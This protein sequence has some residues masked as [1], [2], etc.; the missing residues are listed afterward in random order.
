MITFLLVVSLFGSFNLKWYLPKGVSWVNTRVLVVDTDHDGYWELMFTTYG[1]IPRF[2]YVYE[3][4]PPSVWAVDS[5][6]QPGANVLWDGG[7]FDID[8]LADLAL[9][10]HSENPLADGIMI[11]ESPDSFSYPTQEMWRDTVGFA[12]VMPICSHDVDQDGLPEIFKV[13][14]Y[15]TDLEIY[16]CVGN[17]TYEHISTVVTSAPASSSSPIAFGDF[18]LDNQNDFTWGYLNGQYSVWECVGGNSYQEIVLQQLPT[19]NV[20]DCPTIP[21]ADGDGRPEFLIKGYNP[22]TARIEAFILEATGDNTYAVIESFDLAGGSVYYWGGLSDAGDVDGDSIPEILIEGCQTVYIAKA[23]GNDSF[24]IWETLP[25]WIDGS[26][27]RVFDLDGNGLSEVIISG[28]N[29]TRIYEYE[30]GG[31]NEVGSEDIERIS[32]EVFPNPFRDNT[33][34]TYELLKTPPEQI[35][36]LTIFNVCGRLVRRFEGLR[37]SIRGQI[38]WDGCDTSGRELPSGIYILRF[39]VADYSTEEK[40]LL[41]R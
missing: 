11:V 15:Y 7:D 18:D 25:G 13:S 39:E 8:G 10:F 4:Q 9:Q 19:G 22:S 17:N 31:I 16:E 29:R 28:Y 6:A 2:V 32:F 27:V 5:I 26:C 1:V 35:V 40:V 33:D 20:V 34:I 14:G 36:E 41:I 24:Y 38:R 3:L 37:S 12:A 21:D 30:P 23:T